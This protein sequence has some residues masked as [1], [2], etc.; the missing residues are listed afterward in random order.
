MD[1]IARLTEAA[2]AFRNAR[3]WEQFHT[4][5]NLVASI[6]IEAAELMEEVQWVEA[7]AAESRAQARV[8]SVADEV[9]D[10]AVYLLLLC[11]R[12]DI[13]LGEAIERKIAKNAAKYPVEKARGR[14]V[15]YDELE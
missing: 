8:E 4:T 15:K 11:D 7:D 3:D 9:A 6:A 2:L 10:I 12:L 1:S 14:A 13:D 5:K